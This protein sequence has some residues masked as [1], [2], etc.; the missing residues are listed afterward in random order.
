MKLLL[1]DRLDGE[2]YLVLVDRDAL[3]FT[4]SEHR[5]VAHGPA[6]A[7]PNI[8]NITSGSNLKNVL[9]RE[10]HCML[11]NGL[12]GPD[13]ISSPTHTLLVNAK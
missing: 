9:Q 2:A 11:E 7:T 8:Q 5:D 10:H 4:I 1:S 3:H 12:C 6:N 13:R